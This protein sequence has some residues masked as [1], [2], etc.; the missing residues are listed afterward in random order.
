[1]TFKTTTTTHRLDH[2]LHPRWL[3]HFKIF[4]I[5]VELDI[6]ATKIELVLPVWYDILVKGDGRVVG[7]I[8]LVSQN[9]LGA[10]LGAHLWQ[11][12]IST[13]RG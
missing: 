13:R 9:Q 7:I 1:M 10:L 6:Q 4:A 8:D 12:L 3:G 2:F 5:L 11:T